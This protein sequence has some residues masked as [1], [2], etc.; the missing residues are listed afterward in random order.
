MNLIKNLFSTIHGSLKGKPFFFLLFY[1]FILFLLKPLSPFSLSI[2]WDKSSISMQADQKEEVYARVLI[3]QSGLIKG[4]QRITINVASPELLYVEFY[5]D[6][7]LAYTDRKPPWEYVHNFG[8]KER[9]HEVRAIG[10]Y[11]KMRDVQSNYQNQ[12]EPIIKETGIGNPKVAITSPQA[13]SSITG[14]VTIKANISPALGAEIER[15]EF[16][17]DRNLLFIDNKA[18]YEYKCN[19]GRAFNSRV[20]EVIAYDSKGRR[21]SDAVIIRDLAGDVY[22]AKVELVNLDVTVTDELENYV[23]GLHKS[24]FSIYEDGKKQKISHFTEMEKPLA[25]GILIDTSGSMLGRKLQKAKEGAKKFINTLKENDQAFVMSF[26]NEVEVKEDFTSSIEILSRS[27]DGMKATGAT[28]LNKAVNQAIEKLKYET[29][30]KAIIL[31]SDGYDTISE[32]KEDVVLEAAKRADVKI[33][34]IGIFSFRFISAD[35]LHYLGTAENKP[36]GEIILKSFSDWTGG[37][38]FFPNKLSELDKIYTRI[39]LELRRQYSLGYISNN[40]KRD[41]SWRTIEVRL[42]SENL[43]ARTK[44]GYYAPAE[45]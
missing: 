44:K 11:K 8:E 32:V 42:K 38:A 28:A 26:N 5:I 35:N 3:R 13:D 22:K 16:L 33:Y 9:V 7:A 14:E 23:P 31:L 15:V 2:R 29:G 21:E 19:V 1:A 43:K 34:S 25:I 24:E 36:I 37:E 45:N 10:Y 20:I 17:I 4:N 39:A 30:R 6:T 40:R 18:P 12:Q 41:G 27:I